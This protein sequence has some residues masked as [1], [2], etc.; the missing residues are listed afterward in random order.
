MNVSHLIIHLVHIKNMSVWYRQL[1]VLSRAVHFQN[2]TAASQNVGLSQPQLSRVVSQL[3]GGLGVVLLDRGV[4]RKTTWTPV[5][6]QLA[7]VFER[8]EHRLERAMQEVLTEALPTEI[9]GACLEGLAPLAVQHLGRLAA[10]GH[11]RRIQLDVLDQ[12]ELEERFLAGEVDVVWSSRT[13]GKGKPRHAIEL[14]F[15]ILEER[16]SGRALDILSGY[17]NVRLKKKKTDRQRLISN[18]LRVRELWLEKIGGRGFF[19]SPVLKERA[20]GKQREVL[21]LGSELLPEKVWQEFT[22]A[23]AAT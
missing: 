11:W 3:E 6:H 21:L 1:A 4:K 2:L 7:E 17:E 18:S 23:V 22:R 5:A 12:T 16:D 9:K 19:P 13:P 8:N 20:R 14:G 10:G 15:Q